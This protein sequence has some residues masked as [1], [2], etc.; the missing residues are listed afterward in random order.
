MRSK[1]EYA[2]LWANGTTFD[3]IYDLMEAEIRREYVTVLPAEAFAE[4]ADDLE[5]SLTSS[6]T[7]EQ[8][9]EAARWAMPKDASVTRP[10]DY[11]PGDVAYHD[12][13]RVTIVE[14]M[15]STRPGSDDY[16]V[17]SESGTLYVFWGSNLVRIT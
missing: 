9:Q 2:Q 1:G 10:Q 4:G 3:E 7:G 14:R 13:L 11:E 16:L 12:G 5:L 17:R 6:L 15:A 8:L